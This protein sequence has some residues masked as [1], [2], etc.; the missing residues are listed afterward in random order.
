M[1]A[2]RHA[3]TKQASSAT[4]RNSTPTAITRRRGGSEQHRFQDSPERDRAAEADHDARDHGYGA[5]AD[6][7]ADGIPRD[8][9]SAARAQPCV[10]FAVTNDSTA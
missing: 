5:A 9:P 1:R 7:H 2:A 6:H 4:V 8:A 3:G 10:R